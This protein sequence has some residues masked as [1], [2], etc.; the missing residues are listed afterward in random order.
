MEI[1]NIKN[2]SFSYPEMAYK[3]VDIAEFSVNKGDFVLICG[4]SGCGKTTL[5]KLLKKEI[6]PFGTSEGTIDLNTD[7]IGF[8]FQNPDDQIVSEN[9]V[10]EFSFGL[11]NLKLSTDEISL[12]IAETASYLGIS[13]LMNKNTA[14][15]SGGEKQLV[16]LGAVLAMRPE[17]LLLDEPTAFLDPI[18]AK[19]FIDLIF[20]INKEL[21]ITV[22][23][24]EHS[25]N[26]IFSLSSKVCFIE[27][28]K[29]SCY[30]TPSAVAK[31]LKNNEFEEA[32]PSS[33]RI[34]NALNFKGEIPL[35]V[36]EAKREIENSFK[37]DKFE[38][39]IKSF[40]KTALSAKNIWF[41]YEKNSPDILKGV[42]FELKQ[43]EIL[44]ILG[45]NGSGKTTLLNVLSKL[46]NSYSGKI[47]VFGKNIKKL[48]DNSLYADNLSYLVQNPASVFVKQTVFE[49]FKEIEKD[50]NIIKEFSEKFGVSDLL[51]RH[52]FDLSGGEMQKCALIKVLFKRPKI[53]L[54]DEPTKSLDA[55]FE[56][57]LAKILND[58][59]EQGTSIIIVTH[60]VEFA[61]K[62]S[63]R[64]ALLFNGKLAAI[65]EKHKFFSQNQYYTT[66]SSRISNGVFEN[67]VLPK[68]VVA[69]CQK[70]KG[71]FFRWY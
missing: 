8:V 58:L 37:K 63:D 20:R 55:V 62:V 52:P 26:E 31:F 41:R 56:A 46:C 47:E 69:L 71:W 57:D 44:S 29:I 54:L 59:K 22:I 64:C 11:E 60:N 21:G 7:N 1:L 49:D 23:L 61:A 33:A 10:S 15:L 24:A 67:T 50:E 17:L 12:R 39:E 66:A 28:G 25:L 48:N 36:S 51:N 70:Q 38:F 5:L 35:T 45:S 65:C 4:K 19:K 30:D 43:G 2:L 6:S 13:Y 27:S 18:S 42:S 9:V 3:A 14:E 40:E 34:F 53:L 16:N 32:L 68:E